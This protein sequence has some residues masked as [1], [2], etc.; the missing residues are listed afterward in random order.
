[1]TIL[2]GYWFQTSSKKEGLD[3]Y[4]PE[5][6]APQSG[7]ILH[8]F[9]AGKPTLAVWRARKGYHMSDV[10]QVYR[11]V[12]LTCFACAPLSKYAK[13]VVPEQRRTSRLQNNKSTEKGV[14]TAWL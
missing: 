2:I 7:Y 9:F 11:L 12:L 13:K 5:Y 10:K 6:D 8:H 1:V 3:L 4:N 14:L